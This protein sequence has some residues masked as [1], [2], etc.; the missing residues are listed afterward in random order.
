M[1]AVSHDLHPV[2][3]GT[4]IP[5][6][7]A[8]TCLKDGKSAFIRMAMHGQIRVGRDLGMSDKW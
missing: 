3:I 2:T 7:H 1:P 8:R 6:I 4:K 5:W